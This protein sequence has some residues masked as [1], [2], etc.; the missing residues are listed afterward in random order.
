MSAKIQWKTLLKLAVKITIMLVAFWWISKKISWP[1]TWS[2]LSKSNPVL[3]AA[4]FVFF[5]A[6]KVLSAWRL[7]RFWQAIAVKI[8]PVKNLKLYYIGMYYN[9]FLPGG[10]GGDGYK[11]W[12]LRS[13]DSASTKNLSIAVIV[14]RFSGV[15]PLIFFAI[16]LIWLSD[17]KTVFQPWISIGI[18]LA[19]LPLYFVVYWF[20]G[21]IHQ[22]VQGVFHRSIM[23]GFGVQLLQVIC[24]LFI[25][26]SIDAENQ[27]A[28]LFLF[29]VSSIVAV[30]PLTIGGVGAREW[31]MVSGSSLFMMDAEPAV[32]LSLIFFAIT[33]ISSFIGAFLSIKKSNSTN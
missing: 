22:G 21:K 20:L 2:I 33:A 12:L 18:S 25:L 4:A 32:A 15:I 3:V 1:E 14:D 13:E 6:S 26:W 30:L 28:L 10:I 23:D 5:N 27:L 9:L 19:F 8:D 11:I 7:N 16:V 31:V 17:A 29:L 24:A